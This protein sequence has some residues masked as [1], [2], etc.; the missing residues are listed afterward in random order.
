[1]KA[2]HSAVFVV[3]LVLLFGFGV[4]IQA[5]DNNMVGT[6]KLNL[7]KSTY[8]PGPAP[9]SQTAKIEA[10][11]GGIHEVADR[12]GADGKSV[13]YEFTAMFDGKDYPVSGDPDRDT[14]RR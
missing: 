1:M 11:T 4:P 3:S 6:W 10:V 13:H 14:I 12:V 2:A 9:K 8:S 7:A 5:A